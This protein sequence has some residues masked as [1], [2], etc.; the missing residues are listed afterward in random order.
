[1]RST[2]EET[3]VGPFTNTVTGSFKSAS[4]RKPSTQTLTGLN[5]IFCV[6]LESEVVLHQ[7]LMP[8]ARE[9]ELVIEEVPEMIK[10]AL[11]FEPTLG[12]A[13][14]V[15]DEILLQPTDLEEKQKSLCSGS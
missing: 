6:N 1:M 10:E 8:A 7:F 3:T 14:L 12:A 11:L 5:Y 9:L 13:K 4:Q 2:M 15:I